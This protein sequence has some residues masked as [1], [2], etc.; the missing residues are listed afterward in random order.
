MSKTMLPHAVIIAAALTAPALANAA[1]W[2]K[3]GETPLASVYV[4]RDSMR[5]SGNE[6]RAALEWRWYNPTD[7]PDTNGAKTYR[8]E[9]QVQI[10]NCTNRGY[11]V[12]EGTRYADDRGIELVSSYQYQERSLPWSEARPRTIRDTIVAHVCKAVPASKKP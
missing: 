8:L 7:V 2:D 3:V 4:D 1:Q 11:A 9:R 5:R 6:V 12:L 10:S